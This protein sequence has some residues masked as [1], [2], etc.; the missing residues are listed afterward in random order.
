MADSS[1]QLAH[2]TWIWKAKWRRSSATWRTPGGFS[3]RP[4]E[5]FVQQGRLYDAAFAPS[6][7]LAAVLA[8]AGRLESLHFI[9][10]DLVE[11]FRADVVQIGVLRVLGSVESALL[12]A[13]A[14]SWRASSPPRPRDS[15]ATGATRCSSSRR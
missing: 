11:G 5:A 7:D 3:T 8:R 1:R 13:A 6:L 14:P 10:H 2:V 15:A 9:I 4:A 12:R